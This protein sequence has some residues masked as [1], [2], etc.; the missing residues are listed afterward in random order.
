VQLR[1]LAAVDDFGNVINPMIVDEQVHG[2]LMQGIAQAL[3]VEVEYSSD[4][5]LITASFMECPVSVATDQ[6]ELVTERLVHPA[7]SNA[8]GAK[9]RRVGMYRSTARHR[10]CRLGRPSSMGRRQSRHARHTLPRLGGA[11]GQ[12]AALRTECR[13]AVLSNHR[14]QRLQR[15][16]V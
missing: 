8:L 7:P 11:P 16:H 2:S 1:R 15:S 9:G 12:L 3:Y 5:Q 13:D 14:S 6:I 10:Q 4:G